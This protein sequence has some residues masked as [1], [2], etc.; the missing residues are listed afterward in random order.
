MKGSRILLVGSVLGLLGIGWWMA[1]SGSAVIELYDPQKI[2]ELIDGAGIYGPLLVMAI[3]AAAIVFSPLPS[4]PITLAAGAAYGHT[5]G[6]VY[7]LIGAEVGAIVA[8][9]IAR[10]CG[11]EFVR[12]LIGDKLP[13]TRV[14]TQNGLTA[15]VLVT[16]FLP[17]M[18]FDAVSYA[19]GLT[20]LTALRFATATL[21]GMIPAT[22]LL[23]HFGAEMRA[24]DGT[25]LMIGLTVF[26]GVMLVPPLAVYIYRKRGA[27]LK[28]E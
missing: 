16:R 7:L 14:N 1:A 21:V 9:V 24:D 26:A 19:A 2:Q 12:R 27:V 8:F 23:A 3:M 18:S 25:G 10:L 4:A 15:V 5:W 17:F 6:T 22:F 28:G 11:R 13:Q 20:R